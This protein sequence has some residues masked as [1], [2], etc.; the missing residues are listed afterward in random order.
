[1]AKLPTTLK[2]MLILPQNPEILL[3]LLIKQVIKMH[4]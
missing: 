2:S 1:M 4:R 3:Y